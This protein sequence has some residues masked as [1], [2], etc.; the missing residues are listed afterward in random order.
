MVYQGWDE[1]LMIALI[2]KKNQGGY[3]IMRHTV[4]T[5]YWLVT[6]YYNN[7]P[8][9]VLTK[10]IESNANLN[11]SST[12]F[13]CSNWPFKSMLSLIIKICQ[14][15]YYSKLLSFGLHIFDI[16]QDLFLVGSELVHKIVMV[17]SS[18][19]GPQFARFSTYY[20]IT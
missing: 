15:I 12:L 14:E 18:H 17:W 6:L 20:V 10:Y 8:V 4:G 7:R 11:E 9:H 2:S 5:L 13:C 3:K 16:S 1:I 19:E